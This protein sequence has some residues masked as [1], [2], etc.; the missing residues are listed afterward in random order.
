MTEQDST[1]S[2]SIRA[3]PFPLWHTLIARSFDG[4]GGERGFMLWQV[5]RGSKG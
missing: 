4:N 3:L 2:P 1:L 5:E